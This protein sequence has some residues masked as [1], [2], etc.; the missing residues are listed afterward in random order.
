MERLNPQ[1]RSDAYGSRINR[2]HS[3]LLAYAVPWGTILIGS[4]V[5]VLPI[6]TALPVM[7]PFGYIMLL[8]WRLVRPGLL[9][10]WAGLPLGAFADLFNGQPFG[11][12]ILLWSLTMLAIEMIEQR[13]PWRAFWQ[14]WFSA[15]LFIMGYLVGGWLLSGGE[16]T[17]HSLIALGP[18]I[19]LSIL[20][21]PIAARLV[22]QLDRLRL[23]RWRRTG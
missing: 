17:I 16:P 8:G 5:P 19:V 6:A 18:Q 14:D 11:F 7:P 20:L 9:P 10:V 3:T 1:S 12:A 4:L 22:S 21:F 2:Q 23:R 15:S 13:F